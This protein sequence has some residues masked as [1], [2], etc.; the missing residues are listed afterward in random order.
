[1]TG[2]IKG[3]QAVINAIQ[4]MIEGIKMA[5]Q[6]LINLV[7]SIFQLIQ[8]LLSTVSNSVVLVETLPSWLMAFAL[9]TIAVAVLYVILG[10]NTGK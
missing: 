3:I 5:I 6:F 4:T 9:A 8:L 10:R 2:L 7:H 1:M